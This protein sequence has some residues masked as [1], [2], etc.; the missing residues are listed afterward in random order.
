MK[1]INEI[2]L[3]II[4]FFKKQKFK[5]HSKLY[6]VKKMMSEQLDRWMNEWDG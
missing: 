1:Q 4:I 2:V 3:F 6:R 5:I